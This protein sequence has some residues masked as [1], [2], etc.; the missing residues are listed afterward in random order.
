[1]SETTI[2]LDPKFEKNLTALAPVNKLLT[3]QL[4][5]LATH[6]RYEIFQGKDPIDINYLDTQH[7][8]FMYNVPLQ[9]IEQFLQQEEKNKL[10]FRYFFGMGTGIVLHA[11]LQAPH[12]KRIAIIEPSLELI[13]IALHLLDFSTYLEEKKLHLEYAEN[14][15][16]SK[17]YAILDHHEGLTYARHFKLETFSSYYENTFME[18]YTKINKLM[19]DAF[20]DLIASHG[21]CAI[22]SLMGLSHHVKNLP[23]MI[24]GPKF[25]SLN[26]KTNTKTAIVVSTGPSLSKQL[27]L[28]KKIQ[29]YVTIVC[30]DASFP[31]LEKNGIKADF[32]AVLE[33][34]P[35]TAK[36]F[37]C[38]TPEFQEG[39][40]FVF[41]SVVHQDIINAIKK[42][43][44]IL[45]MRPHAYTKHFKL[46][47]F[48]YIGTGMSAANLAHE[49]CYYISAENIIL[50]GQDLAFGEDNTSHAEGHVYGEDEE[51]VEGHEHF[52]EKYGGGGTIR[53]T[54]YWILFRNYLERA[55]AKAKELGITPTY[56]ATEGGAR[57]PGAIEISF[58]K[59]IDTLID[60]SVKKQPI[61]VPNTPEEE[62]KIYEDQFIA[63][64]ND[65][66]ADSVKRQEETEEVFLAVQEL[67]ERIIEAKENNHLET[68]KLTELLPYLDKID[69]IK[70]YFADQTF[71]DRYIEVVQTYILSMELLLVDIPMREA[72]TEEENL[73]KVVDWI[74]KH[75]YWLFSL[76]GGLQAVRDTIL[77]AADTWDASLRQRLIVPVKKEFPVDEEK[78]KMLEK[79]AQ[80]ENEIL[81]MKVIMK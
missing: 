53:T 64:L 33:R 32:V 56:N 19:S 48:G 46:D 45:Q 10:P 47:Q 3:K 26:S 79:K 17:A 71:S 12:M 78:V 24:R 51:K 6:T 41:V 59:A 77:Q 80:K 29:D 62:Q 36:F 52:V 63:V 68:I 4:L 34:I 40:N 66:I 7:N 2:T 22:D 58:Q 16:F 18:D 44:V 70:S 81:G 27:P 67:S 30:V 8:C 76:A 50:I 13:Y 69:A 55:I 15:D 20:A 57:I 73:A 61:V 42:G 60:T 75:R 31:I 37:T 43:T 38:N 49:L 39:V 21:N 14:L 11:L 54:Y 65:W 35:E 5:T 72:K 28:L 9:D 23:Q 1:M 74:M 25:T